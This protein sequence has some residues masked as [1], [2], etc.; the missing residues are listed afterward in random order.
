[1]VFVSIPLLSFY[2][3][4]CKLIILL[5]CIG[6]NGISPGL[7]ADTEGANRLAAN[8]SEAAVP[9]QVR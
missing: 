5:R 4:R 8:F 7:I 3:G 6:V 2:G 1:M 9:L